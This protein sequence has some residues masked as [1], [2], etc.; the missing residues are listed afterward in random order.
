MH[1]PSRPSWEHLNVAEKVSTETIYNG[2]FRKHRVAT[3][4]NI[5]V[6]RNAIEEA[7]FV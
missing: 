2:T 3:L 4:L 1:A 7:F 5:K 6:L